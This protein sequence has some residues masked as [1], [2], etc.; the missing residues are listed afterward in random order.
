MGLKQL[1]LLF[2]ATRDLKLSYVRIRV[3]TIP[4]ACG[5]Q[6]K[7]VTIMMWFFNAV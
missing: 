7:P 2:P 1:S 4:V 6:M 3:I 5:G